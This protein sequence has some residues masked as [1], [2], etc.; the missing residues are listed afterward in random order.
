MIGSRLRAAPFLCPPLPLSFPGAPLQPRPSTAPS[1]QR[2][3]SPRS[4]IRTHPSSPT[5]PLPPPP[6]GAPPGSTTYPSS[7]V[8]PR[9][10][11]SGGGPTP[12]YLLC[13]SL[14]VPASPPPPS[15]RQDSLSEAPP[16][17][18]FP[19]LRLAG[20]P[21]SRRGP[22]PAAPP[23]RFLPVS[24]SPP[25]P[26]PGGAPTP[27][28]LPHDFSQSPPRHHP[29]LP[30]GPQPRG[31]SHT[32][33]SQP[34]LSAALSPWRG[35]LPEAPPA[36][37]PLSP[38]L[39]D[40]PSPGGL[41]FQSTTRACP[42]NPLP[43]PPHPP[44]GAPTPRR[45]P[46]RPLPAPA[47][48]ASLPSAGITPLNFILHRV[49]LLPLCPLSKTDLGAAFRHLLAAPGRFWVLSG[50]FGYFL[51]FSGCFLKKVG[52]KTSFFSPLPV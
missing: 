33:L 21:S 37:A 35:S 34:R 40:T 38:H 49:P 2:A 43:P 18:A 45:L 52:P 26:P 7:P 14:P 29:L 11:S 15:S 50:F 32:D 28:R 48:P 12:K 24:T 44:G 22:N 3:P 13:R 4:T 20:T 23:A 6:D 5:S 16:S 31:A 25:P 10:F 42:S 17:P 30:A 46:H 19:G 41:P 39:S 1:S 51:G 27:R 36:P 47:S 9:P 8:F